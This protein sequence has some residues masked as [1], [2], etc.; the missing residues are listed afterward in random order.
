MGHGIIEGGKMRN[1]LWW[2]VGGTVALLVVGGFLGWQ[3]LASGMHDH[4]NTAWKED[5]RCARDS[6][7]PTLA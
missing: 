3:W 6:C 5:H 7:E 1:V 2:V 4:S